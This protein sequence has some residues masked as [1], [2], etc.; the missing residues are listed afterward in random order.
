MAIEF[1]TIKF[2]YTMSKGSLFWANASGKLGET[3]YYRSGGEQRNRS[4]VKNVKNPKT[5]AQMR[6]R[7]Q[8]GN[9][10]AMY[11]R[12][13]PILEKTFTNR[14]SAESG[15][16]ALVKANKSRLRYAVDKLMLEDCDYNCLGA[17]VSSGTIICNIEPQLVELRD[18]SEANTPPRY[19]T[20]MM[21]LGDVSLEI[22][23]G[24]APLDP[25]TGSQLY[26]L[27]TANGNPMQLPGDFKVIVLYGS[28]ELDDETGEYS[29]G[30][31]PLSYRIYSCNNTDN[32]EGVFVGN[33]A[34]G[35]KSKIYPLGE[36]FTEAGVDADF[37]GTLVANGIA[38]GGYVAATDMNWDCFGMIIYYENASGKNANN[39]FIYGYP[40][41]A[42]VALDWA[43]GGFVF[44]Q[45]LEEVGFNASSALSGSSVIRKPNLDDYTVVIPSAETPDEG[46]DD[47]SGMD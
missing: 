33:S 46:G 30:G 42:E 47:E 25:L 35:F 24:G 16:N 15:F 4:Y 40:K 23:E 9:W 38:L 45:I 3:V 21:A 2:V 26:K 34:L 1:L 41:A 22:P 14:P 27:L 11:R 31:M 43:E 13:K 44:D 10:A 32:T 12:L 18:P 19:Y 8:M 29:E 39:A 5:E 6:N 36:E 20:R 17:K 37:R 7:I 28:Y